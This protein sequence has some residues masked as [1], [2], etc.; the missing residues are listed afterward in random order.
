MWTFQ[1]PL[2]RK[3]HFP[4]PQW[5]N[6]NFFKNSFQFFGSRCFWNYFFL[7]GFAVEM[8]G[9][10]LF[11]IF[12]VS[13]QD[14]AAETQNLPSQAVP[15][16]VGLVYAVIQLAIVSLFVSECVGGEDS[17]EWVYRTEQPRLKSL[18]STAVPFAVGLQSFNWLLWV[19]VWFNFL[20]VCVGVE[21]WGWEC[22]CRRWDSEPEHKSGPATN[23][24]KLL[25]C[26]CP[27][28]SSLLHHKSIYLN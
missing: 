19:L 3:S 12:L 14:K 18:P 4:F 8:F 10:I 17:R 16:A 20:C 9:T 21:G 11:V 24:P 28:K 15:F 13:L 27:T 23:F 1:N 5:K 2:S 26:N 22:V 6:Q 7:A 25:N